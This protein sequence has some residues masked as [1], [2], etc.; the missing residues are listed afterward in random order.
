MPNAATVGE[1]VKPQVQPEPSPDAT[2][3]KVPNSAWTDTPL[4]VRTS[5]LTDSCVHPLGTVVKSTPLSM[6][7][8][9]TMR[10]PSTVPA[11]LLM[12]SVVKSDDDVLW[13]EDF[14]RNRIVMIA[15]TR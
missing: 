7:T 1:P 2:L 14:E 9:A 10:S 5:G 12:T 3:M 15:P 4:T 13:V 8:P 11:G 6:K